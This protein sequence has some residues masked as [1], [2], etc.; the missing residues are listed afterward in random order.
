MGGST[1]RGNTRPYAEFNALVD[2]EAAESCFE[3][4]RAASRWSGST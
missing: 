3:Q 4:R 1:E 2:P